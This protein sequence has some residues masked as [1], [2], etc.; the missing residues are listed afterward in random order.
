[1]KKILG[2]LLLSVTMTASLPIY[3][4]SLI[5]EGIEF[6]ELTASYLNKKGLDMLYGNDFGTRLYETNL[7]IF[8][9]DL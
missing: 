7:M 4:F 5:Y 2:F 1:M 9:G 3:F 6:A 8:N